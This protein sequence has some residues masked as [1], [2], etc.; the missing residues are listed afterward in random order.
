MKVTKTDTEEISTLHSVLNEMEWLHKELQRTD[1]E[2]ID[3]ED[4]EL[5]Q[6][7]G[8]D[9]SSLKR[10]P[11]IFIEDLVQYI[12]NI[13]FQRILFNLQT[14]LD[15]CA[16]PEARTLEYNADIKKGLELLAEWVNEKPARRREFPVEHV[17]HAE[18]DGIGDSAHSSQCPNCTPGTLGMRRD[19]ET[20]ALLPEDAC[21]YCGQRYM[22]TDVVDGALV[23]QE[24]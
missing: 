4:F 13:H 23:L 12:S 11:V 17:A 21:M 16:D 14:L 24:H 20:H 2:A 22:Y 10:D 7:L 18:L 15:N 3:W 19:P 5:L 6:N 8:I 9:Q 1:F